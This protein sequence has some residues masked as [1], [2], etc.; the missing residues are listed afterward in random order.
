M[1]ELYRTPLFPD[2]HRFPCA[3]GPA[4]IEARIPH[5]PPMRLVDGLTAIDADGQRVAGFRDVDASDPLLAGHFPGN[6]LYPGV[7]QLEAMGQLALCLSRDD[8]LAP[9]IV[10]VVD[11][12]F[13]APVAAGVRLE[14][15]ATV[16]ASDPFLERIAGQ[17]WVDGVLCS[18]TI[19]EVYLA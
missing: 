14:L 10:R 5:R 13:L 15:Q 3:L 6:P 12:R 19:M 2:A 1:R 11:A 7:L 9:R 18:A 16:V 17:A 8:E 4:D